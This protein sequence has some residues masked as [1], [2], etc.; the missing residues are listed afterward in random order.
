[1]K[2]SFGRRFERQLKNFSPFL[3]PS[4]FYCDLKSLMKYHRKEKLSIFSLVFGTWCDRD[5]DIWEQNCNN[6]TVTWRIKGMNSSNLT[7]FQKRK[8]RMPRNNLTNSISHVLAEIQKEKGVFL[9]IPL[10][11]N[12]ACCSFAEFQ[13]IFVLNFLISLKLGEEKIFLASCSI[14]A[15]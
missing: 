11:R 15:R 13:Y 12:T 5:F 9:I 6:V 7:I 3:N 1:M 10:K 8:L 4:C 2:I 14:Y